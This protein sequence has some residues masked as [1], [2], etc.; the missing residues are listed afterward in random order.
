MART[1]A[2][3]N[4]YRPF[5]INASEE[6]SAAKVVK[7]IFNQINYNTAFKKCPICDQE[8]YKKLGKLYTNST[9]TKEFH[10]CL[11]NP[12]LIILDEVDGIAQTNHETLVD[13]II[14]E[15]YLNKVGIFLRNN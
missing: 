13:K 6:R 15:L 9:Q 8:E 14:Q 4:N 3:L 11:K 12:P 2:I 10:E 5:T 1:L 7:K